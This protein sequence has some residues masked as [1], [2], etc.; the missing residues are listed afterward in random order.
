MLFALTSV[1]ASPPHLPRRWL[2]RPHVACV[3]L[4]AREAQ[5]VYGD[6]DPHVVATLL[7]IFERNSDLG[8]LAIG[9]WFEINDSVR[10]FANAAWRRERHD[11]SGMIQIDFLPYAS[12]C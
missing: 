4:D 3:I 8:A 2:P 1:I 12:A 7:E 11:Y 9:E 5:S 10:A 6:I